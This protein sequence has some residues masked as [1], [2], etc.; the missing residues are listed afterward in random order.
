[1]TGANGV[2]GRAVV[3]ACTQAGWAVRALVRPS[4]ADSTWSTGQVERAVGTLNP[5][6]DLES[7]LDGVQAIVHCAGGGR[8]K[9]RG[10]IRANNLDTTRHLLAAAERVS[11]NL[12]RFVFVSSLSAQGPSPSATPDETREGAPITAYG[13]SKAQAEIAVQGHSG[14]FPVTVI[15]PPA[16]YGPQDWR[17]LPMFRA[18][19]RGWVPIPARARTVTMMHTHDC[20]RAVVACLGAAQNTGEVFTVSGGPPVSYRSLV[21][22]L[23]VAVGS[24]PRMVPIPMPALWIAGLVGELAGPFRKQG[25]LINLDKVRDLSQPHWVCGH[26]AI[27]DTLGWQPTISLLDGL[28][29]TARAYRKQGLLQ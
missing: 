22:T 26:Q 14:R 10:Q 24:N 19:V 20:A 9:T 29:Q 15:R 3:H 6:V 18:A 7:A 12:K 2:L 13:R 1:V 11:P 25:S 5:P 8:A 28:T 27:S 21:N 17:M 4:S 23:G 16:L